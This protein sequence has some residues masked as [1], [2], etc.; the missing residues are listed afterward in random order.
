MPSVQ[1]PQSSEEY[2]AVR[3]MVPIRTNKPSV[4]DT[5]TNGNHMLISQACNSSSIKLKEIPVPMYNI[6]SK[7][8]EDK[9]VTSPSG[10]NLV[11]VSMWVILSA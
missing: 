3:N 7:G 5:G 1:E 6:I 11:G 2:L 8:T 9:S 10:E 4:R